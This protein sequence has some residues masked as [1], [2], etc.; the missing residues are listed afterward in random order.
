MDTDNCEF[1]ETFSRKFNIHSKRTVITVTLLEDQHKFMIS[2]SIIL[3]IRNVLDK[4]V[5]KIET[6]ILC[7]RTFFFLPKVVPF[8]R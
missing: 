5:R 6:H 3:I 7:P 4:I 1:F 2:R 8:M